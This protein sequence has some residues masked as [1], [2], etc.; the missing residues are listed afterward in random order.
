MNRLGK[1]GYG[2]ALTWLVMLVLMA[3]SA[4]LLPLPK[5]VDLDLG[6]MLQGP[7]SAHLAGTDELGRDVLSRVVYAAQSTLLIA[8]GATAL[9]LF[10]GVVLGGAAGYLGGAIDRA[11]ILI[12]DLFWSIPFVIFVVLIIS[13]IGV[14]KTSLI[15]TIGGINWVSPARIVRAETRRLAGADFVIA[16]RAHG[17]SELSVFGG[18]ILP[19][20]WKTVFTLTA[21]GAIE[22]ITLETGLAFLG[23]SMPAPNPTWGGMLADGLGYFSSAWWIVMVTAAAVTATLGSLQLIARRLEART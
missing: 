19:N 15:L 4:K 1:A 12:T 5:P 22:V 16:A 10:L 21:Y 6:A 13:V 18:E 14:S 11:V 9:A 3:S 23:L 8:A 7:S 20:L 17:Y 2:V